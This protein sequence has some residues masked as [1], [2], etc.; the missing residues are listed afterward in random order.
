[1]D[2]NNIGAPKIQ[3]NF[4]AVKLFIS[5][6]IAFTGDF[7]ELYFSLSCLRVRKTVTIGEQKY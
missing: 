3:N 6:L 1:M 7:Y 2:E 4:G 5:L